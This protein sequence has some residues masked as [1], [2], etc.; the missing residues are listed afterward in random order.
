MI[1]QRNVHNNVLNFF[2]IDS[3][4]GILLSAT[5]EEHCAYT[6]KYNSR[7]AH[8]AHTA[9]KALATA[10]LVVVRTFIVAVFSRTGFITA[11]GRRSRLKRS[12]Y[13]SAVRKFGVIVENK[14][15]FLFTVAAFP[16]TVS[17]SSV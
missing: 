7:R 13:R 3:P 11:T 17:V 15:S 5:N 6:G 1:A 12:F 9:R 10:A 4:L 16:F 14:E 2:T 8:S